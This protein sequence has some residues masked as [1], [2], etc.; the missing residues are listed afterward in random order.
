MRSRRATFLRPAV[1]V[2]ED[3]LVLLFGGFA[4]SPFFQRDEEDAAVARVHPAEHVVAGDRA[5][6]LDSGR[7]LEDLLTL[8]A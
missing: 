5:D 7:G 1:H 6:V 2:L 8:S 4:I 3:R